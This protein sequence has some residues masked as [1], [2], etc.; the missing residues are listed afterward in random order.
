MQLCAVQ[1]R[2][3]ILGIA[4][5]PTRARFYS[6]RGGEY[7]RSHSWPCEKRAFE[8]AGL[9]LLDRR[10]LNGNFIAPKYDNP[11]PCAHR[12]NRRKRFLPFSTWDINRS[13]PIQ[14]QLA[15][16]FADEWVYC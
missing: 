11:S 10:L 13:R 6:R 15:I 14:R 5:K 12:K 9:K 8:R 1:L 16:L 3:L 2:R 4:L 7:K